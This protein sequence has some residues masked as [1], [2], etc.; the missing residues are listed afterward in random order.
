[1]VVEHQF[2]YQDATFRVKRETVKSYL[3]RMWLLSALWRQQ[4]D[5]DAATLYAWSVFA[6]FLAQAELISGTAP[7]WWSAL[8]DEAAVQAAFAAWSEETGTLADAIVAALAAADV[9]LA[10]AETEVKKT[11]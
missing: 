1:M 7:A 5:P 3:R 6:R 8:P 4:P 11:S 2:T 9:M 10:P